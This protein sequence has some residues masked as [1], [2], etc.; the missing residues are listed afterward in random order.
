MRRLKPMVLAALPFVLTACGIGD[1]CEDPRRYESSHLGKR[2]EAPEGLD[3]LQ[4]GKE[5][6]IPDASPRPP[7][8]EEDP[9][10]ELPPVYQ[11]TG[12]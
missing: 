9:C 8:S 7:R 4:P 12:S 2:I 5:L 11:D 3:S 10:L 6:S 1:V